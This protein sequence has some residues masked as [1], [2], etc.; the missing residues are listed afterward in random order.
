MAKNKVY[1]DVVVD[2]KGT[3]KRV[4]VD[5]KKLGAAL[6]ETGK[7]ARTADKNA[8]GL[9]GTASAGSK[10]FSK[11]AQGITGGIVP[12]YA[13]FAAQIFALTAAFNFLKRAADLENLRKSQIAYSQS[14]GA[15]VNSIT[16]RL[17]QASQGM[18]GFQEAAQSAAIGAAKGFSSSQL[19]K[20]AEGSVK[21]SNRLGRSY[22]DT[23]DRL[24]RGISK[25]EPE[26]LDEL[27]I[28]LRLETA[29]RKYADALGVNVKTL[30]EAQ[31]SQ[32]VYNEAVEQMN[33]QTVGATS[34]ANVFQAL[35]KTFEEIQQTI[36]SKLLPLFSSL[37]SFINKN[38]DA[39]A[40]AFT[41]LGALIL[42]NITGLTQGIKGALASIFTFAGS[43]VGL[44]GKT[45]SLTGKLIG[46]ALDPV[47]KEIKEA[48]DKLLKA[49][50]D[51]AS[52]AQSAAKT[53][54]STGAKSTTLQKIADG[55]EVTPQAL[56]RL[57]KD[58]ARVKKEIQE[59]GETASEA[60]AGATVDG[61]ERVE[62]E[63]KNLG[64][65]SL[66]TGQKIKKGMAVVGAGAVKLLRGSVTLAS[67]AFK[68]LGTGAKIA[69]GAINK[70]MGLAMKGTFLLAGIQ[71]AYELFLKLSEAPYTFLTN[72]EAVARKIIKV[73]EAI[74]NFVLSGA[75]K[76]LK[77]LGLEIQIPRAD[78]QFLVDNME[79]YSDKALEVLGTSREQLKVRED[80]NNQVKEQIALQEEINE[81]FK[82]RIDLVRA[83]ANDFENATLETFEQKATFISGID[84]QE[85]LRAYSELKERIQEE[86][87]VGK[88]IIQVPMSG[89]AGLA[90]MTEAGE[91]ED[92]KKYREDL[93]L[94]EDN[95]RRALAIFPKLQQD[96]LKELGGG[97]SLE[98]AFADPELFEKLVAD[99]QKKGQVI[100]GAY[101]SGLSGIRQGLPQLMTDLRGGSIDTAARSLSD[102]I[103]KLAKPAD[104]SA[105]KIEELST[106]TKE[107]NEALG[108]DAKVL[109]ATLQELQKIENAAQD[110]LNS[111]AVKELSNRQLPGAVGRQAG[112]DTAAQRARQELILAENSLKAYQEANSKEGGLIDQDPEAYKDQIRKLQQTINL[113]EESKRIAD[114]NLTEIGQLGNAVGNSLAS[115]MQSAFDGL[116]QGTMTAKEAFANMA[117]SM[118]QAIAKVIA[119]LLVAKLLTAALGGTSFGTFLGIPARTGGIF[120]QDPSMRYG[121]VAEK[122][123]AYAGGGIAKGR[124]AGYPA[125]LHG[126]EA[127]VP[128][129]NG[130]EIPVQM[131]K[132]SGQ[133]NNVVVNVS[134]DSNGNAQQNQSSSSQQGAGLGKAIAMAV[135]K[136]L[137]NQ[138][139]S[140]GILNP[141]GAA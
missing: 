83:L 52:K 134:V 15:A 22:E 119:E 21:L 26:L 132:G 72:I 121:G 99:Y 81:K 2:D 58:L 14:T 84:I 37:A 50:K 128:L 92:L 69:G 60:F 59:T 56:G 138:K 42:V 140:G 8:K 27:G 1:I 30:T 104:A 103:N 67:I 135:Q 120:E 4:A 18:L 34:D 55:I 10:N 3:T 115:S 64:R 38:A 39:A 89:Y 49:A 139:R 77:A 96:I 76:L 82:Q 6:E 118:L 46:K 112:L 93:A 68:G 12:A 113:A 57:R 47:I 124:Q 80:E 101:L 5:A 62:K 11:M 40:V 105:K 61:I 122:V 75:N 91:S 127:V 87:V 35:L 51:S 107:L 108:V 117:K 102:M 65:T 98:E 109:L 44:V 136:E 41:A 114:R 9:A 16:T 88:G 33:R 111:I 54:V 131:T 73:F 7:S 137:Q 17:Q 19:E 97:V 126:T 106:A 86:A 31:R 129:P 28:T 94:T 90:G 36:T 123:Q 74:I 78:L 63:L 13:A 79:N 48:E 20:L 23:Y 24:V 141:Y 71:A 32:A 130:K 45:A 53:L 25:A 95:I 85:Q 43:S 70:A 29:T 133:T 100:S 66:T 116:I 110:A 125:I